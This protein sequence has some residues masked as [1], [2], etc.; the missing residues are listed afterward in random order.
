MLQS[1][2]IK[3][4]SIGVHRSTLMKSKIGIFH[5]PDGEGIFKC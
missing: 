4:S 5:M 2:F 1:E 3:N